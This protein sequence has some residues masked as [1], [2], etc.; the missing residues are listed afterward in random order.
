[1]AHNAGMSATEQM[2]SAVPVA[3]WH[4][5]FDDSPLAVAYVSPTSMRLMRVN[6]LFAVLCGSMAGELLGRPCYEVFGEHGTSDGAGT[7]P[8]PCSFCRVQECVRTGTAQQ[9]ERPFGQRRLRVVASPMKD[10]YGRAWGTVLMVADITA[11]HALRQELLE[12]QRLATVGVM[13][14]GVAHE[15]KN[16]LTSILGF[17][18]LLRRRGDLPEDAKTHVE[19]IWGEAQRSERIIGNLLKFARRKDAER[20]VVDVNCII[21]ESLEL[22]RYHLSTGGVR[23]HE[24]YH[25]DPLSTFGDYHELQQVVQNILTNAFDAVAGSGRGGN[26][27]V[28]TRLQDGLVT[29]ELENDGPALPDPEQVFTPFYTTK[30]VGKGT[31]LGLSVSHSIIETHGGTIQAMNTPRGVLFRIELPHA[32]APATAL[33]VESHVQAPH[34]RTQSV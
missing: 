12:S 25:P 9:F 16:P 31:G 7:K 34:Q 1:M 11:E 26:L 10:R 14:S 18:Q 32:P 4:A 33:P 19:R 6:G 15:L 27:T 24:D 5:L 23:I 3:E 20:C 30:E 22:L 13:T 29:I 17:V 28:R 2:P 21:K 8:A